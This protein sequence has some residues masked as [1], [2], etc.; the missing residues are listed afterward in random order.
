MTK[1]LTITEL[2]NQYK[3][4]QTLAK[5][6][7]TPEFRPMK[8]SLDPIARN[9]DLYDHTLPSKRAWFIQHNLKEVTI[10]I[11][12]WL[13]TFDCHSTGS[14][15]NLQSLRQ[16]MKGELYA[17]NFD[18]RTIP[19]IYATKSINMPEGAAL[20]AEFQSWKRDMNELVRYVK[21]LPLKKEQT[22][23]DALATDRILIERGVEHL[24]KLDAIISKYLNPDIKGH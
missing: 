18:W 3:V 15:N 14:K 10:L 9:I 4:A 6:M 5:I 2:D 24:H 20:E 8:N 17:N 22:R 13:D 16:M 21:N 12:S 7:Q 1:T 23:I 19:S 11:N